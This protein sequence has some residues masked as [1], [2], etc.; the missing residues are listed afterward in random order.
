MESPG[1]RVVHTMDDG[2]GVRR[3][4]DDRQPRDAVIVGSGYIGV[5]MADALARRGVA[6][7]LTGR[8]PSVLPSVSE[9]SGRLVEAELGRNGVTVANDRAAVAIERH[10][11]R[12]SVTFDDGES[13]EADLVVLA[14]G[15]EPNSELAARAGIATGISGAIEVDRGM[16]TSVPRVFA[17]GDCVETHHA[18]LD[19]PA[20][21]PLGTTAHKQGRVAGTNAAGGDARFAGSVGTQVVKVFDLA[22]AWT[23]L[24]EEEARSAGFDAATARVV[25]PDHKQYYPG[26]RDLN[27]GLIADAGGRLLGAEIVGDW[28]AGVAKRIDILATAVQHAWPVSALLDLDLSYTP[29][30]GSPWDAVQLAADAWLRSSRA[31][32]RVA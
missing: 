15:V 21:L 20:Y 23:G 14:T 30:L 9:A 3:E 27:I 11:S 6:V 5:E 19:R 24:S 31:R 4:L 7:T 32:A 1:V 28:R 12:T 25:V 2:I 13:H 8:S 26:A 16:R 29:P 18:V 10:G 17:A 22:A